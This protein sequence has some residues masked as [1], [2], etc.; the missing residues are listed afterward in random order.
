M[1]KDEKKIETKKRVSEKKKSI[2]KVIQK[3]SRRK[4]AKVQ[5]EKINDK[6]TAIKKRTKV[7]GRGDKSLENNN[8]FQQNV[9]FKF[10][11]L[12]IFIILFVCIFSIVISL[13]SRHDANH[14]LDIESDDNSIVYNTNHK[15]VRDKEVNGILFTNI[16]CS[17]NGFLS[18]ITYT[19]VNHT[20]T[21][22]DLRKYDV[23]IKNKKGDLIASI[24]P[25]LNQSIA[26]NGKFDTGNAIY[27]DLSHAYSMEL[28]FDVD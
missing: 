6:S 17:Y 19:I 9:D 23:L 25:D 27:T 22:L 16:T 18:L 4:N 10:L 15:V 2:S 24:S 7:S 1:K 3:D 8:I 20:N 11:I 26:P 13:S 14:Y 21:N 5:R 12:F 28:S